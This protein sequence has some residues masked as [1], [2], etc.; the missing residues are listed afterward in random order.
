MVLLMDRVLEM[1]WVLELILGV[2]LILRH[3]ILIENKT[4]FEKMGT[5]LLPEL[6]ST[7]V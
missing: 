3:T 2:S 6:C 7:D 5:N 1:V 4:K